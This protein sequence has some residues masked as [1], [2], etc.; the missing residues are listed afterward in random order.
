MELLDHTVILFLTFV[1]A[2]LPVFPNGHALYIHLGHSF[3]KA[4][5]K[6]FYFALFFIFMMS[7]PSVVL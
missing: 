2:A 3:N 7:G 1:G 4:H 6:T 5:S